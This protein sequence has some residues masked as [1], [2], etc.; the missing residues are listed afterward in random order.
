MSNDF[1]AI[2]AYYQACDPAIPLEAHDPRYVDFDT[3]G[4]R[5]S[6]PRSARQNLRRTILLTVEENKPNSA[7]LF[8]G[9]KG[10]G[11][12]T[13]LK[14]L[15]ESLRQEESATFAVVEIDGEK[16]LD[17][18]A[19]LRVEHVLMVLALALDQEARRVEGK[20]PN[21]PE[22]F[23]TRFWDFLSK[24]GI[25]LKGF[26]IAGAGLDLQA[27]LKGNP[28][29][30]ERVAEGMKGHLPAFVREAHDA[31]AGAVVRIRKASNRQQVAV[32]FDS[33]EKLTTP[34]SLEADQV[35][36]ALE[37][38]FVTYAGHL[39]V[40]GC[41]V[42]FTVPVWLHFNATSLGNEY[43]GPTSVILPMVKVADQKGAA[44]FEEG[45]VVLKKMLSLRMGGDLARVFGPDDTLV[46][47]LIAAS[48]GYP[49]DLLRLARYTL[50]NVAD[51]L[52]PV[53]AR[54]VEEAIGLLREE[55]GRSLR[56]DDLALLAEVA[57]HHR[58]PP[59]DKGQLRLTHRL[60]S[61]MLLLCY[62]NGEEWFDVHPMVRNHPLLEDAS[63]HPPGP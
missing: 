49:R 51:D 47:R 38:V 28:T 30:R 26:S 34:R 36:A 2:A 35:E 15:A 39:R 50:H 55:Y 31:I 19:P 21:G 11:K 45:Y 24:T 5:G 32:L 13:E 41:H 63:K 10:T 43:A 46:D 22:S 14:R 48:G 56:R 16:Y 12:S 44:R 42:I 17:M 20:E 37:E 8:S 6:S 29:F 52:L 3:G 4:L 53:K 57:T 40:P 27:E 61:N 33:L 9:F 25:D 62:R 59:L 1:K 60:F 23:T 7:Q 18:Y 54:A 58:L